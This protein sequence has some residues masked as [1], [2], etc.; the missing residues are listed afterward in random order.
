MKILLVFLALFTTANA[1][2]LHPVSGQ[3]SLWFTSCP[4]YR[5]ATPDSE[6]FAVMSNSSQ[7]EK[8]IIFEGTEVPANEHVIYTIYGKG[9]A[10]QRNLYFMAIQDL[11]PFTYNM[12]YGFPQIPVLEVKYSD[13]EISRECVAPFTYKNFALMRISS[14]GYRDFS[15]V[16]HDVRIDNDPDVYIKKVSIRRLPHPKAARYY[17]PHIGNVEITGARKSLK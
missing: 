7:T 5:N 15:G 11:C 8:M 16:L 17:F 9:F 10:S 14:F 2:W 13:T 12:Q 6:G 1:Q 3:E 4:T